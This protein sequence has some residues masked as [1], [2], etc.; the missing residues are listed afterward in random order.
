MPANETATKPLDP[1]LRVLLIAVRRACLLLA[2]AI[3]VVC[4]LP[5]RTNERE[6]V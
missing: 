3:A 4:D 6:Q 2:D 1:R 5:P